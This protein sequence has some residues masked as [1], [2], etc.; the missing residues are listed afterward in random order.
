MS[1]ALSDGRLGSLGRPTAY[2]PRTTA[3]HRRSDVSNVAVVLHSLS[4]HWDAS[5]K[6]DLFL[7]SKQ[8]AGTVRTMWQ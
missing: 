2:R 5:P 6:E 4:C 3:T 1:F 7:A 8:A